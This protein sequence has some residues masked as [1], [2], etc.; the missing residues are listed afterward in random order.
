MTRYIVNEGDIFSTSGKIQHSHKTKFDG[1]FVELGKFPLYGTLGVFARFYKCTSSV[2]RIP[3]KRYVES[4]SP[5]I[6]RTQPGI[7][8]EISTKNKTDEEVFIQHKMNLG[9]KIILSSTRCRTYF[10]PT[11]Q[12]EETN[13]SFVCFSRFGCNFG[14]YVPPNDEVTITKI[15]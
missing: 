6:Y 9:D 1:E 4:R 10:W 2:C 14:V 13:S 8:A 11:V 5:I 3:K 15:S 7:T 12:Q